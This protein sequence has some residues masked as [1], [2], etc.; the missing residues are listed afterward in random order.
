[1]DTLRTFGIGMT[2]FA[3]GNAVLAIGQFQYGQ[4]LLATFSALSAAFIGA[5]GVQTLLGR[6]VFFDA[7]EANERLLSAL[8][9][10]GLVLGTTLIAVGVLAALG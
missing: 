6:A 10:V 7:S 4:L 8:A 9:I 2:V 1:M 3:I 5:V